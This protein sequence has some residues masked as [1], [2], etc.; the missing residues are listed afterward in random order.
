[1]VPDLDEQIKWMPKRAYRSILAAIP[2]AAGGMNH[3]V[4]TPRDK[5]DDNV[6]H[7]G[8]TLDGTRLKRGVS[9]KLVRSN[10]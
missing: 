2:G 1:M 5:S 6:I 10:F 3:D 9:I 4:F 7:S 8:D